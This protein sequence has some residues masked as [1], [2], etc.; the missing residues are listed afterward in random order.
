MNNK[1]R[2]MYIRAII[3]FLRCLKDEDIK[4]VYNLTQYCFIKGE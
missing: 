4:R 1:E 3:R 2:N